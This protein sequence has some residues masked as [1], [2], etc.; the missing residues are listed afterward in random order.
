MLPL[1]SILQKYNINYHCYADDL[2]LYLPIKLETDS[3]LQPLLSCF[4]EI[5]IWMA[6]NFLQ[7][8]TDKTEVLLLGP[9]A[10][11]PTLISRLGPLGDNL[12][13]HVKNLGLYF[14]PLLQ[15]EKHVNMVVKSSF[16]HLQICWES[17]TLSFS[18][19]S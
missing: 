9:I 18:Q 4:D 2:Q 17:K 16:F 6:N 19:R 3:S 14:D 13:P 8:N 12:Q 11:T 10:L 5:R 1:G 15:F 7:L